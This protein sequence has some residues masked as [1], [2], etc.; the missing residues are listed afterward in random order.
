MSMVI[1]ALALAWGSGL[2]LEGACALAN[3][4]AGIVSDSDPTHRAT[5]ELIKKYVVKNFTAA[6][7]SRPRG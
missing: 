6:G 2:S 4:A 1:A 7:G 5:Q 3:Y